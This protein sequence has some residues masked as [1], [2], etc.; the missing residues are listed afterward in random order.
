M[1]KKTKLG[2]RRRDKF[3]HL[4]KE[5]GYRS[6]S[7]FKLIQLNRKFNFLQRSRVLID[8]CAAPGGW[9]QVASKFMPISSLIIGVD[10]VPIKGIPN[11]VCLQGDIMTDKCRQG[12]S[13]ELKTWK[14]DCV[15][16]D[17]SPNVGTNWQHDAFSQARLT[18]AALKLA[19]NFL[20]NGGCFLT[21]VF[22]SRD[23]QALMW[24]FQQLFKKVQATKPQASRNESAE[25]FVVCQGFLAADKIDSKF[26][27]PKFAFKEVEEEVK[28]ANNVARNKKPKAEGYT[29]GDYTQFHSFSVMDFVKGRNPSE[30]LRSCSEIKLD[31]AD[32]A[33]HPCTTDE[34]RECC[35]DIRV[36]GR[37]ELRSLMVWRQ[38]LRQFLAATLKREA[39][40][41]DD[42]T[43]SEPIDEEQQNREEQEEE[44]DLEKQV[45]ELKEQEV[46][47]LKRKKKKILKERHK[48]RTRMELKMDLPGNSIDT[49]G[50][51]SLFKLTSV[52]KSSTSPSNFTVWLDFSTSS[53]S[54]LPSS[55]ETL[56]VP[57]HVDGGGSHFIQR[58]LDGNE[59]FPTRPGGEPWVGLHHTQDAAKG[60]VD[61][62]GFEREDYT[63]V[64][65]L[66]Q[67][68]EAGL[69]CIEDL[70]WEVSLLI[71]QFREFSR[72]IL[73]A[74][75]SV[76]MG[77]LEQGNMTLVE[78][79]DF[80]EEYEEGGGFHE[81]EISLA[82]DLDP[83]DMK[84]VE[85]REQQIEQNK[86]ST[87]AE[88]HDGESVTE[89]RKT[90]CWLI[91]R[92]KNQSAERN[93]SLDIFSGVG[94]E[95]DD[96]V[97]IQL[98]KEVY[99]KKINNEK[100]GTREPVLLGPILLHNE[101]V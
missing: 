19:T 12:L 48:L 30:F 21:K 27:D 35:R 94:S 72:N 98:T 90:L 76:E 74:S 28:S 91:M 51:T 54:S 71:D 58:I 81:D 53:S 73:A 60:A 82:S 31:N 99:S 42:Q 7:A 41:F 49:S 26:F 37:K 70:L 67:R 44:E 39:A 86:L 78:E 4:A 59:L 56:V 65:W 3:Y 15:L 84:E 20:I 75:W 17:G 61:V 97:E 101:K 36:L 62:I 52:T 24:I 57:A 18:L 50:E 13:R 77:E 43:S 79:D 88:S 32:M 95:K 47:E 16:H 69:V 87:R 89:R 92:S 8:L 11:V 68:E 2:K 1:G 34:L 80:E 25:I 46:L 93:R 83:D 63:L 22:R 10:L 6:R 5:T 96:A 64:E 66:D 33:G 14:V 40:V 29:E 45:A 38:K 85:E 55:S 23:Y 9:L 100:G